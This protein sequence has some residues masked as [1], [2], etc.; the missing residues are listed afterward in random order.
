MGE[1]QQPTVTPEPC[2]LSMRAEAQ[3][4]TNPV[5]GQRQR[6]GVM[7]LD[8]PVGTHTTFWTADGIEG[9]IVAL[10]QI[11]DEVNRPILDL[12]ILPS[13]LQL[14]PEVIDNG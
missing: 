9:L 10:G 14:R 2:P 3:I 7:H 4:A 13:G 6:I 8:S 1:T 12:P 11:L 5:T